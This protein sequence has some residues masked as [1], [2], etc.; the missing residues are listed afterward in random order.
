MVAVELS[1]SLLAVH[2]LEQARLVAMFVDTLCELDH[3]E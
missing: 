2:A 1:H 3:I